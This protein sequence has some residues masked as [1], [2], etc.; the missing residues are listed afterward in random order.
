MFEIGTV[1]MGWLL[2]AFSVV[3]FVAWFLG[4]FIS[5]R[6][7]RR[8]HDALM[9]TLDDSSVPLMNHMMAVYPL[10]QHDRT[11]LIEA[12]GVLA[13]RG[14]GAGAAISKTVLALVALFDKEAKEE[15][16]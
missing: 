9:Q 5:G 10:R 16:L 6:R 11:E 4:D 8:N 3:S 14:D 1:G 7:M 2:I 12:A 13:G 15:E